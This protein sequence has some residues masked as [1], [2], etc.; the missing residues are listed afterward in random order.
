MYVSRTFG[1]FFGGDL[2]DRSESA[3]YVQTSEI[4]EIAA[5]NREKS[6]VPVTQLLGGALVLHEYGVQP[7]DTIEQIYTADA[8][9]NCR[10]ELAALGHRAL[11]EASSEV[12]VAKL[13]E[14]QSIVADPEEMSTKQTILEKHRASFIALAKKAARHHGLPLTD[15]QIEERIGTV[16]LSPGP[17]I[18]LE[19][20]SGSTYFPTQ[21]EMVTRF[22]II[23][24]NRPY[25]VYLG[26]LQALSGKRYVSDSV[27]GFSVRRS[28]LSGPEPSRRNDDQEH[29][30][31]LTPRS[32]LPAL[33]T[34]LT[35]II[36]V[37][38]SMG[39]E[40]DFQ[41]TGRKSRTQWEK[42]YKTFRFSGLLY[43]D[44]AEITYFVFAHT[45]AKKVFD[46]YF[47]SDYDPNEDDEL[48]G[49]HA[50]RAL[51]RSMH[52]LS[53]KRVKE[54]RDID[55]RLTRKILQP[56]EQCGGIISFEPITKNDP[57]S[58]AYHIYK[59]DDS[60]TARLMK[61]ARWSLQQ[62]EAFRAQHHK[63]PA[64]TTPMSD[65]VSPL[66]KID[67]TNLFNTTMN[68]PHTPKPPRKK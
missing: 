6:P 49:T 1:N 25:L 14:Q 18:T 32:G 50:L 68:K 7:L 48:A 21:H 53:G 29:H 5:R 66:S 34:G 20:G 59:E 31:G 3:V 35:D 37:A 42:L 39:I 16:L 46:A 2:P 57:L 43:K 38:M 64:Q 65:T 44:L 23:K 12:L 36:A 52:T 51:T 15:A 4:A 33:N 60:T 62:L 45:D 54:I 22:E 67:T 24:E 10:A 13:V 47:K 11:A 27:D 17:E 9:Q 58:A 56:N 30:S 63:K 19:K 26:L 40:I 55:R 61:G 41:A 28:G 8:E